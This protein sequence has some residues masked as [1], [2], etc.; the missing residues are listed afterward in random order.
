MYDPEHFFN[1]NALKRYAL[2]TKNK[3]LKY[4]DGRLADHLPREQV[5]RTRQGIQLAAG[6]G[7]NFSI[8]LR[9][10]WPDQGDP[11]RHMEAA[12]CEPLAVGR[13]T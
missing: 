12:D 7:R 5:A 2:G 8:W 6:A 13:Q 1:P 10:Y 4:N 11:R 3:S 9:A